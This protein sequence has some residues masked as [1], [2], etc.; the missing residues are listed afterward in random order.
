MGGDVEIR[1]Q[2]AAVARRRRA[3]SPR[4]VA[5]GVA[6]T[7]VRELVA[8]AQAGRRGARSQLVELK[9]VE[10]GLSLLRPARRPSPTRPLDD[11]D[12]RRPRAR[13]G[14]AARRGSGSGSATAFRIGDAELHAQRR[15]RAGA[16][17]RGRRVL[18]RPA[19]ADR[20]RGSRPHRPRPPG[21][22]RAPSHAV[23]PARRR[24][25]PRPS[26]TRSP[27]RCPTRPCASRPT[28]RPSPACAASGISS[29]CTSA[30][31]GS[32]R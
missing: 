30:S 31:P 28:R 14:V 5:G 4:H 7:R 17:P 27:P 1:A 22:P 20:R 21:Q 26:R 25:T 19:R 11:A 24:E 3:P 16:R 8:M 12:R 29:R 9:A 18:A 32:W 10:P 13:A 2:P 15:H 23:P 6:A